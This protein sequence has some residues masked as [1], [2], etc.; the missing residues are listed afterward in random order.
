MKDYDYRDLHGKTNS[1]TDLKR[2][3]LSLFANINLHLIS[4]LYDNMLDYL[5]S[6]IQAKQLISLYTSRYCHSEHLIYLGQSL[7][8]KRYPL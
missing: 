4:L 7:R 1:H 3:F 2:L 6:R 8:F 5:D